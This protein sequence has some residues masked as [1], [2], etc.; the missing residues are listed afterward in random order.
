MPNPSAFLPGPTGLGT[1]AARLFAQ[2]AGGLAVPQDLGCVPGP[3]TVRQPPLVFAQRPW[4]DGSMPALYCPLAVRVDHALGEVVNERLVEWAEKIGLHEG[5][6]ETFRQAGFGHLVT[7]AHPDVDDPDRL[8]LAGQMNAAW[9]ACD[10]YYADETELGADPALLASRLALAMSA[11]DA[12]PP[13]DEF[14]DELEAQLRSDPVL[15]SLTSARDHVAVHSTPSQLAR[16][17]LTSFQMWVSWNAYGAWRQSGEPVEAWR[18]LAAR[19]HDSFYTSMTLSDIVGGYEVPGNLFYEERVHRAVMRAGTA[20]V[21]VND[22]H[23]AIREAADELPDCNIVLLVAAERGCTLREAA[24][25]A[26]ALHNDIVAAFEADCHELRALP[27][28]ELHHF[29]WALGAWLGGGLEWHGTTNR[30]TTTE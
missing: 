12:P 9:W 7:L 1:S 6:I 15:V 30:Y 22:L 16:V 14:G 2:P 5:R 29:L 3:R 4:A 11:M 21:I 13:A 25:R 20:A 10:D 8:L 28:P 27:S 17:N 18:Y 19:Q 26:V 23:S 24:E